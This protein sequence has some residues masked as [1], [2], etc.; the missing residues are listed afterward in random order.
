MGPNLGRFIF[1]VGWP[2][3][4]P[5]KEVLDGGHAYMSSGAARNSLVKSGA[6]RNSRFFDGTM[7]YR[8]APPARCDLE[9]SDRPDLMQ[10]GS[11]RPRPSGR[12][13]LWLHGAGLY[14][15]QGTHE[16][17][18]SQRTHASAAPHTIAMRSRPISYPALHSIP[19]FG[20]ATVLGPSHGANIL[21]RESSRLTQDP[22]GKPG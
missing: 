8:T 2:V 16:P 15:A 12:C 5:V 7:Q 3:A 1:A 6:A 22:L 9:T 4:G 13:I 11:M 14:F 18:R 21:V 17:I 19:S 10:P 20:N